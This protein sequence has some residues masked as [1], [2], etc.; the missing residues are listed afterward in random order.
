[1]A[2]KMFYFTLGVMSM[3]LIVTIML[4]YYPIPE[5]TQACSKCG[6]EAWYFKLAEG[7]E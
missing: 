6:S 7:D 3:G 5:T 2:D 4:C 1:M